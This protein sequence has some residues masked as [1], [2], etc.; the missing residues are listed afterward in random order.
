MADSTIQVVDDDVVCIESDSE[1]TQST[2]HVAATTIGTHLPNL[3]QGKIITIRKN[4]RIFKLMIPRN[5]IP[6]MSNSPCPV[7]LNIPGIGPLKLKID[8]FVKYNASS[9]PST[10]D[11]MPQ[12]LSPFSLNFD[13][14]HHNFEDSRIVNEKRIPHSRTRKKSTNRK[15]PIKQN[16]PTEMDKFCFIPNEG[17][18]NPLGFTF[19]ECRQPK[20][21]LSALNAVIKKIKM[22][23]AI[24]TNELKR[25]TNASRKRPKVKTVPISKIVGTQPVIDLS[26]SSDNGSICNKSLLITKKVVILNDGKEHQK[27][28]RRRKK[29]R[30]RPKQSNEINIKPCYV[31]LTRDPFVEKVYRNMISNLRKNIRKSFPKPTV[32]LLKYFIDTEPKFKNE[33][34]YI[35]PITVINEYNYGSIKSYKEEFCRT[36][37]VYALKE[38]LPKVMLQDKEFMS[39]VTEGYVKLVDDELLCNYF[40]REFGP[41]GMH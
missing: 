34:A 33:I 31:A 25:L 38:G 3:P 30:S 17:I 37:I 22:A 40:L 27:T 29:Q 35:K 9:I 18:I 6:N 26:D 28:M 7:T 14:I 15:D 21:C 24:K 1:D 20:K 39:A 12:T 4:N 11:T 41:I 36:N 5:V 19:M 8:P 13:D 2:T 23:L 10:V 16:V 32:N